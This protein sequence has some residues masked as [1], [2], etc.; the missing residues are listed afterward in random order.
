MPHTAIHRHVYVTSSAHAPAEMGMEIMPNDRWRDHAV[1]NH[2]I[3]NM[4]YYTMAKHGTV[5]HCTE[6]MPSHFLD[7]CLR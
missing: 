6:Q 7:I 1:V 5:K 4:L 2:G 3:A